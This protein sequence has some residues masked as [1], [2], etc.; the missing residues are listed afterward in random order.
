MFMSKKSG[1]LSPSYGTLHCST[2]I[3]ACVCKDNTPGSTRTSLF[4]FFFR[5]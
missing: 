2:F 5:P 4:S 1:P 3:E